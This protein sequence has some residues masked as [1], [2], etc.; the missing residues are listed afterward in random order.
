MRRY[1]AILSLLGLLLSAAAAQAMEGK[2]CKVLPEFLDKKG[3]NS[4]APS[5][6]ERDA[7]QVYL[8]KHPEK[9]ATLHLAVEYK[10][11]GLDWSKAKLRADLRGLI[12][13][14]MT[15]V[16]MEVPVKRSS[17]FHN[18]TE[19]DIRGDQFKHFGELV[20]WRVSLWQGDKELS[21]QESFLWKGVPLKGQ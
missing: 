20:A 4:M 11:R 19:F 8:R 1:A 12:G 17:F 18:W 6:Y 13:D 7:Y 15:N 10:A 21:S 14:T 5:L 16:T 2:V 3:R 9:R